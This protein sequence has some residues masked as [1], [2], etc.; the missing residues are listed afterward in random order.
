MDYRELGSHARSV[1]PTKY[2]LRNGNSKDEIR[3]SSRQQNHSKRVVLNKDER[4]VG[5]IRGKIPN[6]T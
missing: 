2:A 5:T 3:G 6:K 1:Y 4:N